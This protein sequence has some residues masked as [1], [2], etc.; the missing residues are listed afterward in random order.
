MV[1]TT[2]RD[3][4]FFCRKTLCGVKWFRD[5]MNM[6]GSERGVC[7]NKEVLKLPAEKQH[8]E[9]CPGL[10]PVSLETFSDS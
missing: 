1:K 7:Q 4:F 5:A 10:V 8:L 3:F 2:T 9:V 6:E